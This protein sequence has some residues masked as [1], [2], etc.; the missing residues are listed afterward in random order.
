M[1]VNKKT[2]DIFDCIIEYCMSRCLSEFRTTFQNYSLIFPSKMLPILLSIY[3]CTYINVLIEVQSIRVVPSCRL[4]ILRVRCVCVAR[5][6]F[7]LFWGCIFVCLVKSR[8]CEGGNYRLT[9]LRDTITNSGA[10]LCVNI[11]TPWSRNGNG[12]YCWQQSGKC[13]DIVL[14]IDSYWNTRIN[15]ELINR[16]IWEIIRRWNISVWN[17]WKLNI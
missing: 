13:E 2:A 17:G 6:C 14:S 10:V 3:L 16:H 15:I 12:I 1:R 9:Q 5:L 11:W 7:L 8:E 4:Y